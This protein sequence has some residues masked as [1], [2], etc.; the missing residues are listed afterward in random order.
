MDA[1]DEATL[2]GLSTDFRLLS[3]FKF[4]FIYLFE[5]NFSLKLNVEI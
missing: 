3:S 4:F 1:L 5:E 2:Q